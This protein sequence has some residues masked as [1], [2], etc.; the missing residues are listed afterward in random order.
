MED[1]RPLRVVRLLRHVQLVG[2]AN[3]LLGR[4]HRACTIQLWHHLEGL[5]RLGELVRLQFRRHLVP[6]LLT[7]RLIRGL[8]QKAVTELDLRSALDR[9][10]QRLAAEQVG[11]G[12]LLPRFERELGAQHSAGDAGRFERDVVGLFPERLVLL[13]YLY[14]L[15]R[16]FERL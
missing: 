11:R 5:Q 14:G 7:L 16:F 13:G 6:V 15:A 9:D 4:R 3:L 12:A 1:R 8:L 2:E 10:V